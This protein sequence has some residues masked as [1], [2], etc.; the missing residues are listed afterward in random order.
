MRG[1]GIIAET[2]PTIYKSMSLPYL[3][4][5]PCNL[6]IYL[7]SWIYSSF[8]RSIRICASGNRALVIIGKSLVGRLVKSPFSIWINYLIDCTHSIIPSILPSSASGIIVFPW[9]SFAASRCIA[10]RIVAMEMNSVL[11]AKCLPKQILNVNSVSKYF[12]I[13]CNCK[14]LGTDR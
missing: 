7:S 1:I 13:M 5:L 4:Y 3:S 2:R 6:S 11:L 12:E 8:P 14:S 10:H 9:R